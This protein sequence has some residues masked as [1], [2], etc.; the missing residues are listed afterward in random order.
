MNAHS[1]MWEDGKPENNNGKIISEYLLNQPNLVL[2]TPKNLGTRPSYNNTQNSTIDLTF[3]SPALGP[4]TTIHL[5]PYWSSDHLP[6]IIN[7]NTDIPSTQQI[8]PNWR[9]NEEKWE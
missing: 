7:I 4:T 6:I 3:T 8:N 5:G 9:F 1:G 2:I